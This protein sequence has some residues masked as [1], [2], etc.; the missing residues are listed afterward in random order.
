MT[1]EIVLHKEPD[2]GR[3]AAR[4][5]TGKDEVIP[6]SLDPKAG[7]TLMERMTDLYG[8][9]VEA[10]VREI[11]SNAIDAEL[12]VGD[13]SRGPVEVELPTVKSPVFV[14][15][16]HGGG[17]T[18][19]DIERVYSRY[20]ATTKD[21]DMDAIGF[22]GLGAKA[23]LAY[24]N[25]FQG[26]TVHDGTAISFA[27]ERMAGGNRV[28]ITSV[29]R[30]VAN[31]D[32]TT[33]SVGV[34]ERDI[35]DFRRA[36]GVYTMY[37]SGCPM[38]VDGVD[39]TEAVSGSFMHV[40]D[41]PYGGSKVGV[42]LPRDERNRDTDVGDLFNREDDSD[43]DPYC[44]IALS[45]GGWPYE[46]PEPDSGMRLAKGGHW[47]VSKGRRGEL[48]ERINPRYGAP[49][50]VLL[51]IGP[52]MVDFNSSR[53]QVLPGHRVTDLV[54]GV[55]RYMSAHPE[56]LLTDDGGTET[57]SVRTMARLCSWAGTGLESRILASPGMPVDPECGVRPDL[58]LLHNL[59]EDDNRG[60]REQAP[61]DMMLNKEKGETGYDS[62]GIIK[63]VSS[64]R[65]VDTL[66][67]SL[68]AG[69]GSERA[70]AEMRK[71]VPEVFDGHVAPTVDATVVN[72]TGRDSFDE[73]RGSWDY[74]STVIAVVNPGPR[75][76]AH[77]RDWVF[78]EGLLHN[79]AGERLHGRV[80]A[81]YF[82][83]R[84]PEGLDDVIER[85]EPLK[86]IKVFDDAQWTA[87]LEEEAGVRKTLGRRKV[88]MPDVL[89]FTAADGMNPAMNLM[90]TN[91]TYPFTRD[92]IELL[93]GDPAGDALHDERC[94]LV[95]L[96]RDDYGD[97]T[98][99][100]LIMAQAADWPD[101]LPIDVVTV[102]ERG[103]G[104]MYQQPM[105]PSM[106]RGP[107]GRALRERKGPLLVSG[108]M[109]RSAADLHG[110]LDPVGF[111]GGDATQDAK[112]AALARLAYA[113]IK[114]GRPDRCDMLYWFT[115]AE[116]DPLPMVD[117]CMGPVTGNRTRYRANRGGYEKL[118]WD[119]IRMLVRLAEREGTHVNPVLRR[120]IAAVVVR[121][122]M[123]G[124][125]RNGNDVR[126]PY[127]KGYFENISAISEL[128]GMAQEPW[129]K[130]SING[131]I[132]KLDRVD[133]ALMRPLPKADVPKAHR[134][135]ACGR[136]DVP[137]AAQLAGDVDGGRG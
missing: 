50:H 55:R 56:E 134:L 9:P 43:D 84:T 14:V 69:K 5:L 36:G 70:V 12:A 92:G 31:G 35:D 47:F 109:P 137:T 7:V 64:V 117:G 104:T 78:E 72:V 112:R 83:G 103:D 115:A 49:V 120:W 15:R 62:K 128:G 3:P 44:H 37:P 90:T 73:R 75:V 22:Y 20:G 10:T 119:D 111:A 82:I 123:L 114:D 11:V 96:G 13:G 108:S 125:D 102:G 131:I 67:A 95:V 26:L 113:I 46:L 53:D 136:W 24:T 101:D 105:L 127:M 71:E 135:M 110:G 41:V 63:F 52:G 23:P 124:L 106:F 25:R 80:C 17:M 100:G 61:P 6:M 118:S 40:A 1:E 98:I 94:L 60:V 126:V 16:D 89:R 81:M 27:V 29:T 77:L 107:V 38:T 74:G 130:S 8:R 33:I 91:L 39:V 32:G 2:H 121:R 129:V 85:L 28:V 87:R 58:V 34:A 18:R 48:F 65:V 51:A 57:M 76:R 122:D 79:A 88:Q 66:L 4:T 132:T 42:W 19:D 97:Y 21:G 45:L 133:D 68:T 54:D 99:P 116:A 59:V 93:H 30:G 86:R